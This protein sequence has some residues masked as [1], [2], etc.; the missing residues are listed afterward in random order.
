MSSDDYQI[1]IPPSF[2][3]VYRDARGRLSVPLSAFRARY[4]LCE[5]MAQ[6]LVERSQEVHHGQGVSEDIVLQRT[7][8]GLA[9]E[10]AGFG[11]AEARWVVTRLAELLDW[12]W[13]HRP[14]PDESAEDHDEPRRDRRD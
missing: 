1:H 3:A 10:G 5:D 11:A 12:P 7:E 14:A 13:V 2:E 9:S 6:L 4:E 8:D